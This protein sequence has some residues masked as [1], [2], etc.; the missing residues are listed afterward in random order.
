MCVRQHNKNR[1]V[2]KI[3]F[4]LVALPSGSKEVGQTVCRKCAHSA[5]LNMKRQLAQ[6]SSD[7]KYTIHLVKI[8]SS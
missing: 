2:T 3:Q 8:T 1:H 5:R 6:Q 4:M 7:G